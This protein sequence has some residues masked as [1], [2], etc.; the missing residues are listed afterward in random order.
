M[1]TKNDNTCIILLQSAMQKRKDCERLVSEHKM[2]P[3]QLREL[4]HRTDVIARSLIAEETHFQ[5]E[6]E[7]H[8]NK[9][10]R[11]HL[12]EQIAFYQKIVD[13][14]REALNMFDE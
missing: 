2:E 11:T 6:R 4:S 12:T 10:V 7:V 14:L 1:S 3:Q 8:I 5:T 9:A 13:K